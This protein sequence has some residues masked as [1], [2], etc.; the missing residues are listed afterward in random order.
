MQ[1]LLDNARR[2][3]EIADSTLAAEPEDFALLIKPDGALHFVMETAFSMDG[4]A[5]HVGAQCA[6]RVTRSAAGVRVE[7][8]R[9]G[10]TQSEGC[11]VEKRFIAFGLLRDRP[12]YSISGSSLLLASPCDKAAA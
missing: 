12:L 8:Q 10:S 6:F 4:A 7:G 3:F 5:Q 11:V 2:I 9:Y 1:F